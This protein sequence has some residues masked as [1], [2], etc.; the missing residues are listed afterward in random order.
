MASPG[1]QRR[2]PGCSVP[3]LLIGF[4]ADVLHQAVG[5][6][7]PSGDLLKVVAGLHDNC[8]PADAGEALHIQF[9]LGAERAP[10]VAGGQQLDVA[11]VVAA[12]DFREATSIC[13]TSLRS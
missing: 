3:E 7:G 6:D 13:F 5:I 11:L 2:S 1:L 4:A 8:L 10:L 12:F 9:D